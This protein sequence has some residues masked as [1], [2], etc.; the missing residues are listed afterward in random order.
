MP[1]LD[2]FQLCRECKT[3]PVLKNIPFIFYTATYINEQ[4]KDFALSLGADRFIIKPA[5][6]VEFMAIVKEVIIQYTSNSIPARNSQTNDEKLYFMEYSKRLSE[7]LESKILTLEEANKALSKSEDN[8]KKIIE[9][10]A[11]SILV[12]DKNGIIKYANK[13]SEELYNKNRDEL[14]GSFFGNINLQ[15]PQR[16]DIIGVNNN[17]IFAEA[18]AVEIIWKNEEVYLATLRD[19]TPHIHLQKQLQESKLEL[20]KQK[21]LMRN[22]LDIAGVIFLILDNDGK[23]K[24][25][26]K[27]GCEIIGQKEEDIIGQNWFDNFVPEGYR[28]AMVEAHMANISNKIFYEYFENA[29]LTSDNKIRIIAWHKSL[30]KDDSHEIYGVLCSGEDITERKQA[31]D[32]LKFK[33]IILTTQQEA[34]IDGILSVDENGKI[35]SFNKHFIDI[36]KIPPDIIESKSDELA[37]QSILDRVNEPKKFLEKI[38]YLYNHHNETSFDEINLSD[39]KILERYSVPMLGQYGKYYGRIWYFRDVTERK[40]SEEMLI[41]SEKMKDI[42]QLSAGVAHEFNNILAIIKSS[43]QLLQLEESLGNLSFDKSVKE[44][45]ITIDKQTVRG[46]DIVSNLMLFSKPDTTEKELI[47]IEDIIDDVVKLQKKQFEIENIEIIKNYNKKE[48]L[49]LNSGQIQQVFLNLSINARHAI[50]P[51]GKG[52][53]VITTENDSENVIVTIKDDGIGMNDEI[54][55]N[56]F[57]PFF[58]TKGA[59]ANDDLGLKGTGLG[60]SVSYG[61]IKKYNGSISVESEANNGAQFKII[62]PLEN[63]QSQEFV[64]KTQDKKNIFNKLYDRNVNILI[65]DDEINIADNIAKILK[66]YGFKN[67]DIN[68]SSVEVLDKIKNKSFDLFFIDLLM[69]KIRGNELIDKISQTKKFKKSYIILMS[70]S[71]TDEIETIIS[72]SKKYLFLKKPF[73]SDDIIQILNKIF[74]KLQ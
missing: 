37:I 62:F 50:K 57:K 16:L 3:D 47:F 74:R 7:K 65:V 38:N 20:I 23:V 48:K 56:I 34:S 40:K 17:T 36:W 72:F 32:E 63:S 2:G 24:L 10:N 39:G 64:K 26:N 14:I 53:I 8:L 21:D 66:I 42:A 68:Y 15:K 45:L 58:T 41:E 52:R 22:H 55:K 51:K 59:N 6:P 49:L 61:I 12:I 11:D 35:I 4:D 30:I 60:L 54:K 71:Y 27:K 70:G 44:E 29:I 31:E 25:I 13:K 46:A 33:N 5:E 28:E 19:I 18:N 1:K 67:V 43:S 73:N 69:P 9:N